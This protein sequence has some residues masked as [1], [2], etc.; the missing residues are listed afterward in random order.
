MATSLRGTQSLY[1]SCAIIFKDGIAKHLKCLDCKNQVLLTDGNEWSRTTFCCVIKTTTSEN[2]SHLFGTVIFYDDTVKH[3]K[4]PHVRHSLECDK[5]SVYLA[6]IVGYDPTHDG[7]KNR[8]L[9]NLAI[10]QLFRNADVSTL[11]NN[12]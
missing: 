12:L 1:L 5:G 2:H 8:C 6:G 9:T 7:I 11:L 10:S 3:L 4:R